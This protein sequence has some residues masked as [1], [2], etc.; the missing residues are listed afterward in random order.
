MA[1]KIFKDSRINNSL[2]FFEYEEIVNEYLK[3]F[4]GRE[5]NGGLRM[6]NK[7]FKAT[8]YAG[9]ASENQLDIEIC[10][11]AQTITIINK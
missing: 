6:T 5:I 8:S 1:K 3:E 10:Y 11:S 9:N 2:S 4:Y 7:E